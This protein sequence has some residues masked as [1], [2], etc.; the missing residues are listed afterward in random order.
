MIMLLSVMVPSAL[1][2]A[3]C[4]WLSEGR[5]AR[6][7]SGAVPWLSVL[8]WLIYNKYLLLY[9]GGGASMWPIALLTAGT[10]AAATGVTMFELFRKVFKRVD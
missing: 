3:A 10:I 2:G 8:A 9:Q 5:F 7:L 6:V 1:F 4:A